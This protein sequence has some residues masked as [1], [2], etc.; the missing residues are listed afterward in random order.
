VERFGAGAPSDQETGTVVVLPSASFALA[1]LVKITAIEHYEERMLFTVLFLARPGVRLV[2]L[3]SLPVDPAIVDYY[4]G[5]LADPEDARR[6]LRLVTVG[7][8]GPRPL[9]DK[10]LDHPAAID[11][12]RGLVPDPAL[13]HLLCFMVGPAE[14]AVSDA[15]GVAVFGPRPELAWWGSKSGSRTAAREAGVAVFEGA[16]D[17]FSL[18]AVEVAIDD[19][20]ARRPAATTVVV[21]LNDGFSGQGNAIVELADLTGPL[22]ESRTTFCASGES[23]PTFTDKISVQG[24]IVEELVRGEGTASPSAQVRIAPSGAVEVLSTHDQVLG[25]PDQQVYLGCRFPARPDYRLD[26]QGAAV[27]V[28]D[29]L[30]GK[31]VIGSFGVD[32]VVVP[33]A[34]GHEIY[35]SEI[36]LRMG[37]TTHTF[38]MARLATGGA[39]DPATGQLR[40]GGRYKSY[41]ATDNLKHPGL[42]GRTAAQVIEQVERAGL[43]YDPVR[44]L[45]AT[46]HLLGALPRFGKMGVTCIADNPP[47][48]AALYSEVLFTI[49]A[50]D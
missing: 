42:V 27:A 30:A 25:G 37:G 1:E 36:N 3:T 12:V 46:L 33:T 13:A 49:G 26:V 18:K 15:L 38:W 24:A 2:Y 45:G 35:L 16:E 44:R 19:I 34:T 9:A 7:E 43:G 28:A 22:A 47:G 17:L 21:K 11:E 4:L 20:R 32:F 5:F 14:R 29:V 50:T 40:A 39:Y 41:V 48:A 8:A 6:R 31:G 10:V 23:W